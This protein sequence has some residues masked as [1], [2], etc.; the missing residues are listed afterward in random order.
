MRTNIELDDQMIT[1][2]MRAGPFTTKR[3]AVHA[4]LALLAKRAAYRDLLALRGQLEWSDA[5]VESGA[6]TGQLKPAEPPAAYRVGA[7][8]KAPARRRRA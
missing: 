5:G 2:A 4:G 1:A 7:A 8:P 3:E 6:L